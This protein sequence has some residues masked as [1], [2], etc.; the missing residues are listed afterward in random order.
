ML[1]SKRLQSN[2]TGELAEIVGIC[3]WDIFSGGHEV[4][5]PD[6]RWLDI[7]SFRGAAGFIADL[8]NE[9]LETQRYGYLDFYLGTIW[10]PMRADVSAV[11]QMIFHRLRRRELDW[12]FHFPINSEFLSAIKA[13]SGFRCKK[14]QAEPANGFNVSTIV[15]R[16]K[17]SQAINLFALAASPTEHWLDEH[18]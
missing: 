13:E 4:I 3:L 7:G 1:G 10:K 12:V 9:Q 5:G 17:L 18:G 15:G 6:G 11:Y 16:P 2:L 14:R 8:L